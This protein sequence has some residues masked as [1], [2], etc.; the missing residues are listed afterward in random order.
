MIQSIRLE[1]P[2]SH[3]IVPSEELNIEGGS[4][5]QHTYLGAEICSNT[6]S[7]GSGPC[8][9]FGMGSPGRWDDML[10]EWPFFLKDFQVPTTSVEPFNHSNFADKNC[11]QKY[12][13]GLVDE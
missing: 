3:A 5:S 8:Q 10:D 12:C 7:M 4:L 13:F 1:V 11:L 9:S 6:R 2:L